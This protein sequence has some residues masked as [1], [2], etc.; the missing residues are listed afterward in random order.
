M[1]GRSRFTPCCD[2]LMVKAWDL[3]S[4]PAFYKLY[5]K[6]DEIC[7]HRFMF[8]A[9][10]R[11]SNN[12][13]V[14]NFPDT[15]VQRLENYSRFPRGN[16]HRTKGKRLLHTLPMAYERCASNLSQ[17]SSPSS[18]QKHLGAWYYITWPIQYRR[19]LLNLL[20]GSCACDWYWRTK[21]GP[22]RYESQCDEK[23]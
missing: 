6:M 7:I 14:F 9:A 19:K 3:F 15:D 2:L 18:L 13:A 10:L 11:L 12:S 4:P 17:W 5:R 23:I 22:N 8:M 20:L 21:E 16:G 1:A